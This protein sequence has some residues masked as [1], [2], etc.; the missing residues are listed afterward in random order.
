VCC[1]ARTACTGQLTMN[2]TYRVERLAPGVQVV[3]DQRLIHITSMA[4][5]LASCN[6]SRAADSPRSDSSRV[7]GGL[8]IDR[9]DR[10]G[11]G[12]WLGSLGAHSARI[13]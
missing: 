8:L 3:N 1:V 7:R 11:A 9:A 12:D 6:S 4:V 2:R 5:A 10:V 13:L